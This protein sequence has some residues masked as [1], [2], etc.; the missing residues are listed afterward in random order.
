MRQNKDLNTGSE[1]MFLISAIFVE[2]MAWTDFLTPRV[3]LLPLRGQ[4]HTRS[5]LVL[6]PAWLHF[7][8]WPQY[9]IQLESLSANDVSLS[10]LYISQSSC[11]DDLWS[12]CRQKA[13]WQQLSSLFLNLS[14]PGSHTAVLLCWGQV[15]VEWRQCWPTAANRPTAASN[16]AGEQVWSGTMVGAVSLHVQSGH[17]VSGNFCGRSEGAFLWRD[18]SSPPHTQLESVESGPSEMLPK[19]FIELQPSWKFAESSQIRVLFEKVGFVFVGLF[20]V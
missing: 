6:P 20:W 14:L 3:C 11:S 4:K 18:P 1:L 17:D 8:V 10:D 13:S 7:C 15:K 16:W 2:E 19:G 9:F 12:S 5:T